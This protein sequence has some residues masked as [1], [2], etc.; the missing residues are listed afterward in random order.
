MPN[1]RYVKHLLQFYP[2]VLTKL[3]AICW[4]AVFQNDSGLNHLSEHTFEH[5]VSLRAREA[6]KLPLR[7]S[8]EPHMPWLRHSRGATRPPEY[9]WSH[10]VDFFACAAHH[11]WSDTDTSIHS[12][13]ELRLLGEATMEHVLWRFSQLFAVDPALRL[14]LTGM[15]ARITSALL[16]A[17]HA[18]ATPH[19]T[20]LSGHD[21]TTFPLLVFL[22]S[23]SGLDPPSVWPGYAS[24]VVLHTQDDDLVWSFQNPFPFPGNVPHPSKS[25][26][27]WVETAHRVPIKYFSSSVADLLA[28]PVA[29]VE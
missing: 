14:G 1:R 27:P 24:F 4:L 22:H 20:L 29:P 23:C 19:V 10:I 11:G 17:A 5:S 6:S 7:A 15:L 25:V 13:D 28:V 8:L 21:V 12:P 18:A 16:P 2:Q 9:M 26:K 3:F